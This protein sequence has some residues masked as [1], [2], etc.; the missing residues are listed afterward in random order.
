[1]LAVCESY[2]L[3]QR[4]LP[5]ISVYV[6]NELKYPEAHILTFSLVIKVTIRGS[7]L[8]CL[9]LN[10]SSKIMDIT[11]SYPTKIVETDLCELWYCYEAAVD[12]ENEP[13]TGYFCQFISPLALGSI[14]K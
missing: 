9:A 13:Q 12:D 4:A 6:L 11:P 14:K 8:Q 3:T 5:H 1:M 10:I 2:S 7:Q